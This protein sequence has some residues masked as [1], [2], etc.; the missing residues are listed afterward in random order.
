L[1]TTVGMSELSWKE[2]KAQYPEAREMLPEEITNGAE[3]VESVY[4]EDG[5]LMVRTDAGEWE[6]DGGS[7]SKG[8]PQFETTS[9]PEFSQV[10]SRPSGFA[11]ELRRIAASVDAGRDRVRTV[12]WLRGLLGQLLG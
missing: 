4:E 3:S 11:E 10:A 9:M 1:M 5:A 8:G 7:W 2:F 6:W 12:N